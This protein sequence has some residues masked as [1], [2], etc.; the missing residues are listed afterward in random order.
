MS[1]FPAPVERL[2]WDVDPASLDLQ[3]HVAYVMERVMVR[4]TWAA[5]KWLLAAYPAVTIRKFLES[6]RGRALPP[7]VIAFWALM[8]DANVPIERGGGRPRWVDG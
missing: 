8:S 5:M 7:E 4:G 1:R 6:S 2:F 3:E